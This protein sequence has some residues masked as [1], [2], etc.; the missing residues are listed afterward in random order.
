[1]F[2]FIQGIHSCNYGGCQVQNGQGGLAGWRPR[3]ELMLQFNSE[4]HNS[5]L[6]WASQSAVLFWPSANWMRPT[7]ARRAIGVH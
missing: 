7:T 6:P 3:K 2:I 4:S 5:F 1:M